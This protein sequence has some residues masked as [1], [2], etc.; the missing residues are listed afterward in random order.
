MSQ[1]EF[2]QN[3]Q[4][5]IEMVNRSA[6]PEAM[7]QADQ[8]MAKLQGTYKR[9]KKMRTVLVVLLCMSI[10]AAL[11]TALFVPAFVVWVVNIGVLGCGMAAAVAA[12]RYIRRY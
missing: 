9:K 5:V 12:D 6:A 2:E 3:D 4:E 8:L 10:A 7:S 1:K 11:I